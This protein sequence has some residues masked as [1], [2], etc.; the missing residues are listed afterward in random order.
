MK[1]DHT[2]I[3]VKLLNEF[4]AKYLQENAELIQATIE[5]T[6]QALSINEVMQAKPESWVLFSQK[7]PDVSRNIDILHI[8]GS[9]RKDFKMTPKEL[10]DLNKMTPRRW[11]YSNPV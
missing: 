7:I 9:I 6:Q 1:I 11:R 4:T 3:T 5:A 2:E 8:D 10:S